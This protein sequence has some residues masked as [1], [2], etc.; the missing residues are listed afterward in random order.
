MLIN[1]LFEND[2]R[3][4]EP[5]DYDGGKTINVGSSYDVSNSHRDNM[6]L[7][8]AKKYLDSGPFGTLH[9]A[10][11]EEE[12]FITKSTSGGYV[13][14]HSIKQEVQSWDWQTDVDEIVE[15]NDEDDNSIYNDWWYNS[16]D[17][18]SMVV[19][20]IE[21]FDE[22]RGH[23]FSNNNIQISEDI[24]DDKVSDSMLADK[25]L[26]QVR[27]SKKETIYLSGEFE[28]IKV[29]FV[30]GKEAL[31][32][33]IA[34]YFE[35]YIT[36]SFRY[37]GDL[38][39]FIESKKFESVF[40]HEFQHYLDA[41]TNTTSKSYK[42]PSDG[43]ENYVNQ[44]VEY[45]AFF[46]QQAEPMLKILKAAKDG[47]SLDGFKK[48]DPDFNNYIRKGQHFMM[49]DLNVPDNMYNKKY[50]LKYLKELRIIHNAVTKV[51]GA[52]EEYRP[53]IVLKTLSFLGKKLGIA[54]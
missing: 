42:S 30:K 26:S 39:K 19:G 32:A 48:I 24:V 20:G 37:R 3:R 36:L 23:S 40:R 7:E 53:T 45:R 4:M 22:V 8:E 11:F 50:K 2:L 34:S 35:P 33:M 41:K 16:G 17:E 28:D 43:Y 21:W 9:H 6:T 29:I 31:T 44:D 54:L 46:M 25:A 13:F 14:W 1:Q 5:S 51:V 10:L 15:F 49:K 12:S 38:K 52:T 27:N 18:M 47:K